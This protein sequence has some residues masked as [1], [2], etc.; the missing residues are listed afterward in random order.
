[1]SAEAPRRAPKKRVA[2]VLAEFNTT[3]EVLHAAEKV[4]DA[5]FKS[6]DVHTPFPIHGM[7]RAMGLSDSKLGWIVATMAL[8]GISAAISMYYFMN[9][10]DY[11]IIIGGKPGF[12]P[13]AAFPVYFELTV[14]FSAFG[15]VF[16]MF[17][18]NRLPRHHHPVFE[19]DRFAA[20]T[21]DKYFISI[22]AE[23]AK[24]DVE[25]TK[26][27]LES[28]HPSHVEVVEEVVS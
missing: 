17:H 15:T 25:K 12:S 19:S 28:L 6:W 13:P 22:E 18:L 27:F 20:A 23:D 8:M 10:L 21:D 26:G 1:M 9:G 4:R 5:G 24:F 16:G 11:P 3:G 2:L 14:L 7:D